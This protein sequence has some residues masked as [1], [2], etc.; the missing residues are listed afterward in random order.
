MFDEVKPLVVVLFIS[1]VVFRYAKPVAMTFC[2]EADF[3]RRRN[4]WFI[5]TTVAFLSPSFWLYV[6]VAGPLSFWAARRDSSPLSLYILLLYVAPATVSLRPPV[7]GLNELFDLDTYR[8]LALS[9]LVPTAIRLRRTAPAMAASTFYVTDALFLGYGL[10]QVIFFVQPD[11]PDSALLQDSVTNMARRG[12]LFFLDFYV[13]YYVVSRSCVT[14]RAMLEVQAALCFFGVLLAMTALFETARHW[15]LYANLTA[16]WSNDPTAM[17]YIMRG[18]SL[19]AQAAVGPTLSLGLLLV[20][21]LGF[22]LNIGHYVRATWV[23][24]TVPLIIVGGLLA[25]FSRGPMLGAL[26]IFLASRLLGSRPLTNFFKTAIATVIVGCIVAMTPLGTRIASVFPMFGGQVDLYN[27]TYRERLATRGWELIQQHPILGDQQ[28]YAELQDMRQGTGIV[29]FVN[30]FIEVTLFYGFVGA[31]LL[32]GFAAV[33]CARAFASSR[34]LAKSDAEAARLGTSIVA[35][36]L[37]MFLMLYV[38]SFYN[39]Y[40]VV[41]VV[42]VGLAVAYYRVETSGQ[43]RRDAR[44]AVRAPDAQLARS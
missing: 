10:L 19:R 44:T 26:V 31:A 42:L 14:Y 20:I 25:S 43:R 4:L 12:V 40:Q 16:T 24:R 32:F 39:A 2:S 29:D 41:Y 38:A 30:S 23:R 5:L 7:A 15:L 8:L 9:V 13:L 3:R 34:R 18:G 21:A 22:W 33:G 27:I 6:V 11:V 35:C 1:A 28:A 36:L 37:G 17:M